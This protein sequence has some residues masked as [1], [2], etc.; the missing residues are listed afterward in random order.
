MNPPAGSP[1]PFFRD[2]LKLK[3]GVGCVLTIAEHRKLDS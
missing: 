1:R 2:D 3:L